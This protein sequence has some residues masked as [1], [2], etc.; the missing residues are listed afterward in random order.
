MTWLFGVSSIRRGHLSGPSLC[1]F[2][3]PSSLYSIHICTLLLACLHP[4]PSRNSEAQSRFQGFPLWICEVRVIFLRVEPSQQWLSPSLLARVLASQ[5]W[6]ASLW[7]AA[8]LSVHQA[9]GWA[10]KWS[11]W[12]DIAAG[13]GRASGLLARSL[14]LAC[15]HPLNSH[16]PA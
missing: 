14:Q 16:Q 4:L 7:G 11:W 5:A 9:D 8:C 2:C 15:L 1:S 13:I 10:A 6:V 3:Q 12:T